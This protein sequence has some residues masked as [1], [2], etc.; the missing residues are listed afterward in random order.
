MRKTSTLIYLVNYFECD[1]NL[2]L[3]PEEFSDDEFESFGDVLE[4]LKKT[5]FEPSNECIQRIVDYAKNSR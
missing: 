5:H 4:I 2:L 3:T 1:Q